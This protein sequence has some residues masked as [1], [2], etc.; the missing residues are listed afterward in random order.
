MRC[1]WLG[2]RVS[3]DEGSG[4]VEDRRQRGEGGEEDPVR[5]GDHVAPS[6]LND[7]AQHYYTVVLLHHSPYD[8][9]VISSRSPSPSPPVLPYYIPRCCAYDGD[10]TPAHVGAVLERVFFSLS[11]SS[12]RP[13]S[14]CL[15]P[16][17]FHPLLNSLCAPPIP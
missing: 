6:A 13:T 4:G 17:A 12:L 3:D 2:R 7:T 10:S 16:H 1:E 5:I 14:A 15:P 8:L 9:L 11:I